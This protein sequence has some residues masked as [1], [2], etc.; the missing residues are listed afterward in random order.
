MADRSPLYHAVI[1]KEGRWWIGRITKIPGV[2][3]Q[4]RTKT[5]LLQSLR[6]GLVEMQDLN[7]AEVCRAE[8]KGS[9]NR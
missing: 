3:C 9:S 6:T 4:E 5:A 2:N 7:R 8:Q 1:K